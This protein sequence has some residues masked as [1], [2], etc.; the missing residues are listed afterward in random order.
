MREPELRDP[1]AAPPASDR[2]ALDRPY[3]AACSDSDDT[4]IPL[5]PSFPGTYPP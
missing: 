1:R 4:S 2:A 3:R 5:T